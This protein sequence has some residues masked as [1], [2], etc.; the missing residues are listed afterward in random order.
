MNKW[1]L[2]EYLKS[3]IQAKTSEEYEKECKRIAKELEI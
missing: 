1:Q 3:A 2:Y